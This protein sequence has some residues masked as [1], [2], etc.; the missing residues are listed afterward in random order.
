MDGLVRRM[1]EALNQCCLDRTA[2]LLQILCKGDDASQT[3]LMSKL[4]H[5]LA[6][7]DQTA[8]G[9]PRGSRTQLLNLSDRVGNVLDGI[10]SKTVAQIALCNKEE[11]TALCGSL[12]AVEQLDASLINVDHMVKTFETMLCCLQQ[13]CH[14][15]ASSLSIL[16]SDSSVVRCE[17]LAAL[18][19]LSCA[20]PTQVASEDEILAASVAVQAAVAAIDS[21]IW[22]IAAFFGADW[23][24]GNQPCERHEMAISSKKAAG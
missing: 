14:K 3:E 17:G 1:I 10:D 18:A 22:E 19:A 7:L 13:C 8:V 12:L 9:T 24:R 15:I 5:S 6:V 2:I 16:K 21:D 23:N 20:T 4:E 11:L